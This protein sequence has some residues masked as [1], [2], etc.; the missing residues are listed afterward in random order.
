MLAPEG[1]HLQWEGHHLGNACSSFISSLLVDSDRGHHSGEHEEELTEEEHGHVVVHNARLVPCKTRIPVN[2]SPAVNRS[3]RNSN[4][5]I[6][7][8]GRWLGGN[9][10]L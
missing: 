5:N 4:R 2:L 7:G 9:V 6:R 10:I 8:A 3:T 1:V